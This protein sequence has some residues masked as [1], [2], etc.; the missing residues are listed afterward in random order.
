MDILIDHLV[1]IAPYDEDDPIKLRSGQAILFRTGGWVEQTFAPSS[2][3]AKSRAV[4]RATRVASA[5]G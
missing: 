5:M 2:V 1:L 4:S 3:S